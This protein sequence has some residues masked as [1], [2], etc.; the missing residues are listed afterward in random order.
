M[1]IDKI[2]KM[3][4]KGLIG[5]NTHLPP[6]KAIE[7][8]SPDIAKIAPKNGNHSCWELLH[9][10]VVWQE[11]ILKAI[12][13][14]N[15]D[16]KAISDKT[17]WPAADYISDESNFINLVEKFENGLILADKKAKTVDLNKPMP[18]WGDAPTLQAYFV[19]LQHNS[20]HLGQ[21]VA[22]RKQL[23]NWPS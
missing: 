23:G 4:Q 10:I 7:G 14:N 19:L 17:N 1:E 13:G 9:H 5:K 2:V 18:A 15:V 16:W 3:I 22:V 12:D 20:Y 6:N 8:F 21:I 11:A